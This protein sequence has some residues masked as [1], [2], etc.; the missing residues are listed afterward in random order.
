MLGTVASEML[1][2]EAGLGVAL[3]RQAALFQM[4][5]YFATLILLGI[6]TTTISTLLE[7]IRVRLL[8]WQRAHMVKV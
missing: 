7:I 1:A 5:R 3:Q 8:R 6:M 2:G 4:N